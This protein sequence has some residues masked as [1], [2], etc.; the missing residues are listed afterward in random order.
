MK[1]FSLIHDEFTN[2]AEE[3]K[4]QLVSSSIILKTLHVNPIRKIRV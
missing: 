2:Y 4:D 1:S 3:G